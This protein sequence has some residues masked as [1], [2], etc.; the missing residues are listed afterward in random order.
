MKTIIR[1]FFSTLRRFK[2]ATL[3]NMLGLSVAF[4]AFIV[5]MMQVNYDLQF[6]SSI[7]DADNV[8]RIN[9]V[10]DGERIAATPR[11]I[12]EGLAAYSPHIK[13]IAIN[14]AMYATVKQFRSQLHTLTIT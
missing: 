4:T 6:D 9:L 10:H 2:M 8:Y 5:I 12:G 14:N 7:P 3:L 11:P 1:N 13:A